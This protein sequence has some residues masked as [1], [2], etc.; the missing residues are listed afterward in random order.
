MEK[1][2]LTFHFCGRPIPCTSKYC[3]GKEEPKKKK[4]GKFSGYSKWLENGKQLEED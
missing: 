1:S 3:K 2:T 4:V